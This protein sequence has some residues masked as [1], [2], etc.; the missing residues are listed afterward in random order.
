MRQKTEM[1]GVLDC[2]LG[3]IE[4]IIRMLGKLKITAKRF[5]DPSEMLQFDK[6]VLPGVGSFDAGMNQ[7]KTRGF[8]D[9]ITQVVRTKNKPFLGICLGMQLFCSGSEEGITPG[10]G[11][12]KAEVK[13]IV[14]PLNN[15]IKIPN[16][17]W[18]KVLPTKETPLFPTM[19]EE[20][21]FY[22]V[23]SYHVIPSDPSIITGVVEYGETICAAYQNDNIYGVQFH[24]EKS[25]RFGMNLLQRFI[26]L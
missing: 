17:G 2:G 20:N 23:H 12:V 1:I 26:N 3:N 16:M 24:P 15:Q 8:S 21:R 10:L 22:F 9:A 25:H 11:L 14:S 7:L 13:K 18:R 5:Q 4:S 6:I 19:N